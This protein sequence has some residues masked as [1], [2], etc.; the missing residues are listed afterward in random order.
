MDVISRVSYK[1]QKETIVKG[2]KAEIEQMR[3]TLRIQRRKFE[4]FQN[5]N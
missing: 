3:K 5:N 1:S 4:Q 2:A